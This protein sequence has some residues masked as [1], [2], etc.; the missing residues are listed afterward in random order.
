[1]F[2]KFNITHLMKGVAA[3]AP[4]FSLETLAS[5][6]EALK[7]HL[8]KQQGNVV[9]E[10]AKEAALSALTSELA[11]Q[12]KIEVK[13]GETLV[14]AVAA[15]IEGFRVQAQADTANFQSLC[16]ALAEQGVKVDPAK[17]HTPAEVGALVADAVSKKAAAQLASHSHHAPVPGAPTDTAGSTEDTTTPKPQVKKNRDPHADRVAEINAMLA[18]AAILPAQQ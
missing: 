5:N 7:E 15:T 3:V 1:M 2:R 13:E 6:P 9:S 11:A 18:K 10:Q 12:L 4:D 16:G 14:D 17:V 8:D